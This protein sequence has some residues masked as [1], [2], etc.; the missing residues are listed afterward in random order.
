MI[1]VGGL[2]LQR[3]KQTVY[4]C[5]Q[6]AC[7]FVNSKQEEGLSHDVRRTYR[8][9]DFLVYD[10]TLTL[11]IFVNPKFFPDQ[12]SFGQHDGGRVVGSAL[13]KLIKICFGVDG[14]FK[15]L[16]FNFTGITDS[17]HD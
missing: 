4:L 6:L 7:I 5:K 11:V 3:F 2:M 14:I 17:N 10:K 13:T 9:S 15:S 12:D 8:L 1:V 16:A